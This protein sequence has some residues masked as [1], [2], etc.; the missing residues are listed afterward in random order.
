MEEECRGRK[1]EDSTAGAADRSA[2]RKTRG[3]IETTG[4][5]RSLLYQFYT[6]CMKMKNKIILLLKIHVQ[7]FVMLSFYPWC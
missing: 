5:S 2:E 3:G 7:N 4:N 6:S 1:C